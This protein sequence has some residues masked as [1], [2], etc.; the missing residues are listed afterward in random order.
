MK[1]TTKTKTKKDSDALKILHNRYIKNDPAREASLE[2]ERV[3]AQVA[4]KR[5]RLIPRRAC[6]TS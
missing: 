3:N 2:K 6:R 5:C 1:T 4:R